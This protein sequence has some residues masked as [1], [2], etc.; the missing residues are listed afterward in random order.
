[1]ENVKNIDVACQAKDIE[2]GECFRKES[3]EY[4]YLRISES[5][6]KFFGYLGCDRNI[7]GVCVRNGNLTA[8]SKDKIVI[9]QR[10]GYKKLD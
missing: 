9:S 1:M 8:V 5:S 4:E 10:I 7:V 6:L 2:E 3:G